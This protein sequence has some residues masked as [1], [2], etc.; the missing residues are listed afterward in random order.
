MS[1]AGAGA[2]RPSL[3]VIVQARLSSSRLPGKVLLQA[4]GKTLLA[5][6]LDRV[7]RS[8]YRPEVVVA[9]TT[10]P[11]DDRVEAEARRCGAG[12]FRGSE[13]DVLSRFVGTLAEHPAEVVVRLTADNPLCDPYEIDRVI[14][15]FL[16]RGHGAG[17]LDYATN[18]TE[19]GGRLPLGL[20]VEVF[21][22][23]ALERA[24]HEAHEAGDREH[25]TAYLYRVPGRFRVLRTPYPMPE[26][27]RFRLTVDTPADLELVRRSGPMPS[28]A[29]SRV[30]WRRTRRW[31]A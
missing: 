17:G 10:H 30:S 24:H 3:L 20:D 4:G 14:G 2:E 19:S 31:Q 9:T 29:R 22:A 11:A 15:E 16:A 28:S 7:R 5:H 12:V 1:A 21:R 27:S 23:D 6:L 26:R 25:V 8:S 18:H 13:A